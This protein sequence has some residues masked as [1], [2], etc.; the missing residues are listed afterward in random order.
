MDEL[1]MIMKNLSVLRSILDFEI[2][3]K[4]N[5]KIRIVHLQITQKIPFGI[6]WYLPSET[7]LILERLENGIIFEMPDAEE[8]NP[9]KYFSVIHN[10][11]F[12]H[13]KKS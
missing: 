3:R 12:P 9:W 13:L 6:F 7:G 5:K 11:G 1:P 8:I 4:K 10:I 2:F